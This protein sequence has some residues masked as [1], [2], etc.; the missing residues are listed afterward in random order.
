ML[1][2]VQSN[3]DSRAKNQNLDALLEVDL[4]ANPDFV[5]L[6]PIT[7]LWPDWITSGQRLVSCP[8][9]AIS[10]S[11]AAVAAMAVWGLII[12]GG[13]LIGSVPA[14]LG[15]IFVLPVLGHA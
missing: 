11:I 9:P 6:A 10:T 8:P 12:A 4:T 13:L 7:D 14:F 1:G 3:V 5:C 15:L 2:P